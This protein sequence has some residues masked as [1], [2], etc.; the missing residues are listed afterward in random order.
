MAPTKPSSNCWAANRCSMRNGRSVLKSVPSA[1]KKIGRRWK[2]QKRKAEYLLNR[3]RAEKRRKRNRFFA[4]KF[5]N[6]G[7]GRPK[8]APFLF[9]L[10]ELATV[11]W[12]SNRTDQA[13]FV[14]KHCQA[15]FGSAGRHLQVDRHHHAVVQ[16]LLICGSIEST[17]DL[18]ST[19][20]QTLAIRA[21]NAGIKCHVHLLAA[22]RIFGSQGVGIYQEYYFYLSWIG[23]F[24]LRAE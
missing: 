21:E 19:R 3:L 9:A 16:D 12:S 13:G 4:W 2:R 7:E 14:V 24:S 5:C 23:R 11:D 22:T 10:C 1:P 20:R 6:Y 18:D 15:K 17:V 8:R